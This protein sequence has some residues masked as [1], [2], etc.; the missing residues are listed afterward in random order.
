[1]DNKEVPFH[2]GD[3]QSIAFRHHPYVL[4]HNNKPEDWRTSPQM[5]VDVLQLACAPLCDDSGTKF[6]SAAKR[7]NH[8]AFNEISLP[9]ASTMVMWM[10]RG[11]Q[12]AWSLDTY[13]LDTYGLDT[14]GQFAHR[15]SQTIC[16]PCIER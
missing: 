1:M 8:T 2:K 15:Q 14:Y 4:S 6:L 16:A 7:Q 10:D 12:Y 13:D 3:I 5:F 9:A 11:A